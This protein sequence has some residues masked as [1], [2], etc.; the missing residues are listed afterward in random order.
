MRLS[1]DVRNI[2]GVGLKNERILRDFGIDNVGNLINI[3]PKKYIDYTKIIS[4]SNLRTG[5]VSFKAKFKNIISRR[6]KRG[7]H[8]TEAVAYD[9]D[10]SVKVV[11]FNQ[12]YRSKNLKLGTEYLIN[13]TFELSNN[14]LQIINPSIELN[15]DISS[16]SYMVAPVYSQ[17]YGLRQGLIKNLIRN[18]FENDLLINEILP[19][20]ILNEFNLI[21]RHQALRE[22]HIPTSKELL[23]KAIIR[24]GFEEVY[25]LML[26]SHYHRKLNE[27]SKS[28]VI[29]FNLKLVKDFINQLPFQLTDSQKKVLWQIYQDIQTEEPTNRLI[30][31]D[32]GSGKTVVAAMAG[33]MAVHQ[34]FKV[35][36]IAPT[37]ILASQHFDTIYNFFKGIGYEGNIKLLTSNTTKKEKKE[38]IEL[39]TTK[40][41]F[42]LVG[43]HALIQQNIKWI[44]LGLLI[45]DEQHRFGVEQRQAIIKNSNTMPHIILLTATPIPRTLAL[46]LYGELNISRL[47]PRNNKKNSSIE[48]EIVSPNSLKQVFDFASEQVEKGRQ[49]YVVCPVIKDSGDKSIK[50]VEYIYDFLRNGPFSKFSVGF[51]HGKLKSQE[52]DTI[53]LEYKKRKID[54]LVSTTVIEV[55]IDV[56]NATVMIIFDANRFGLAQLH[57]L[58]GRVGRGQ[59][60]GYC[61]LVNSDSLK[62]SQRLIAMQNSNNGYEL[63]E[64]DLKIRGPG[65]IYGTLQHGALDLNFAN[66]NDI[67]LL[68]KVK[69]A[70]DNYPEISDNMV[71]Y[72]ELRKK[73]VAAGK[74]LFFN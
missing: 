11:W 62:P 6:V 35:A 32:V 15:N 40:K 72:K 3:F 52:K 64:L 31:G 2:K 61:F 41:P 49:V 36:F 65:A 51:I 5:N 20:K 73:V 13:G 46:T 63:A 69:S 43:T 55:G 56:P 58:R 70:V 37:E 54:I 68:K 57:Q 74:L 28:P 34:N 66:I 29:Q 17:K 60:K 59:H 9:R 22:L 45:I 27:K 47:E 7:L 1:D 44:N 39:L 12:P 14:R 23:N 30:E 8:L 18:V 53:M 4:I 38:I 21:S 19:D 24:M 48:S 25:I 71:E 50:S 33:L 10:S 42:F 16:L 26:A 67:N